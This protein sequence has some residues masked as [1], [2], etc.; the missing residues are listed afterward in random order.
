MPEYAQYYRK[1]WH[2]LTELIQILIFCWPCIA[3]YL[4]RNI[5]Y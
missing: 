4:F 1:M 5:N 2:V 3:I